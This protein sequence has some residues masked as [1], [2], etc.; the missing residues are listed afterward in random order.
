MSTDNAI[1]MVIEPRIR[2]VG[3]GE[4]RRVLPFRK[5]RMVG[6]FIFADLMGP[7]DLDEGA[8]ADV[9]AHPHIGLS[10]LTYLT[11]GAMVHRDS[12]GAVQ[13]IEPGAVNWMTAGTG[14]CHTERSPQDQRER[15]TV[16]AGLQA[17]VALPDEAEQ[18]EPRFEHLAA[19]DVPVWEENGSTA[20]ILAGSGWGYR[21]PVIGSSPLLEADIT[22]ADSR[23][24]I[25]AQ[26]PE[27][28]VLTMSG[29]ITV[30]GRALPEGHLAVLALDEVVDV[31]GSGRAMLLAGDPVGKRYI[32]WNF[33]SSDPEVINDAKQRWDKQTFPKVPGDHDEWT[34]R[35]QDPPAH[36]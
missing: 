28:G 10:T 22:L 25:P 7:D 33:V 34:P 4:V 1:E 2:P 30:A 20:R 14:V 23:L 15:P 36:S 32:W 24:S 35:P 3:S 19:A 9:P 11:E 17:W 31:A 6:P 8:G 26:Y 12:I 18:A 5:R 13:R 21:S 27:R 29:D 16:L